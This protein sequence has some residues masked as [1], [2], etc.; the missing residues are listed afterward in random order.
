MILD[1]LLMNLDEILSRITISHLQRYEMLQSDLRKKTVDS[2]QG[3]QS[4]FNG[5]Y[6]MQRRTEEWY[7][8]YFAMLE[9]EKHNKSI[10]FKQV[11]EKIYVEKNRVEP[12]F[13]SKLVAT[14]R[15]EMPVYDKH[16][17]ENLALEVLPQY[18]PSNER[19]RGLIKMYA[20]LEE[21]VT[22][23]VRNPIFVSSLRPAFDKKFPV[24]E[25]ISDVKKLDFLLWQ[26]RKYEM[27]PNHPPAS[28]IQKPRHVRRHT[29]GRTITT[30]DCTHRG[31]GMANA[32]VLWE[33]V[34]RFW[35]NNATWQTIS[36]IE[37]LVPQGTAGIN[38]PSSYTFAMLTLLSTARRNFIVHEDYLAENA[39][40][41]EVVIANRNNGIWRHYL[42]S[43]VRR[44]L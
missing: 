41:A 36:Q 22:A 3:Y 5:F 28:V 29:D 38:N 26:Y 34:Q 14:I 35:P 42:N 4:I 43:R 37:S 21:K 44:A 10:T 11:L 7:K 20:T 13:S 19:I 2:D 1:S 25:H 16:V 32:D 39:I 17:R 15:P 6:K 33:V 23:F 8:Y 40:N 12:S 9:Q 18:K 27:E 24:Y 30:S 31:K